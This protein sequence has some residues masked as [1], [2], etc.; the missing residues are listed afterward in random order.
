MANA[1]SHNNDNNN[2]RAAFFL[3]LVFTLFEISGGLWTNSLAILSNA[4]H[5]VGDSLSL[6]LS[7]YFE[8]YSKKKKD[9]LFSYGYQRFSLLAALVNTIILIG[10]SLFILSEAIPRLIHPEHSKVKGLLVFAVVGIIVNSLAALRL[11]GGKTFVARV[12][13]WHFVEDVM[14]WVAVLVVGI[15]L[16]FK[17]IP[18]LDPV[19]SMLIA[20]YVLY[21]V[22]GNLKKTLSVFLQAVP[23]NINIEEV[24]SRLLAIDKVKSVHHTNV[25]SLDGI[26]HVLTTHV[27]IDG[28]ASKDNV[29][30]TKCAIRLLTDAMDFTHSTVE[31]EY[32]GEAC[33]MGEIGRKSE[34]PS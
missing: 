9:R 1:H 17:D 14:G 24:E 25:W 18:E 33:R 26:H 7:W 32:E 2:I 19:L 22:A 21:N 8:K 27:V 10:G 15:T 23:E 29:L 16:L 12:V 30:D 28:K 6:G 11:K 5:D 13:I 34:L 3:N 20:L 4:L 31:I